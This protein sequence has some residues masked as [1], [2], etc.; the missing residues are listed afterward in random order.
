VASAKVIAPKSLS[1]NKAGKFAFAIGDNVI[2]SDN[3]EFT[4]PLDVAASLVNAHGFKYAS[5]EAAKA[6]GK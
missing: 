4:V 2:E 6:A 1:K 5:A 3:G